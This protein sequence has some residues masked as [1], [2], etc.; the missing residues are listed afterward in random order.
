M[1]TFEQKMIVEKVNTQGYDS[2]TDSEKEVFDALEK[3]ARQQLKNNLT[4]EDIQTILNTIPEGKSID[5]Y[6][7]LLDAIHKA[8]IIINNMPTF[9]AEGIPFVDAATTT[10]YLAAYAIVLEDNFLSEDTNA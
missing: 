3:E 4:D 6:K 9:V 8:G 2:L 5:Y 7:G 10:N 1:L